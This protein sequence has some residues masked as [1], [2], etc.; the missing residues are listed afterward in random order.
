MQ[1]AEPGPELKRTSDAA[2][3]PTGA[4]NSTTTCAKK[5]YQPQDRMTSLEASDPSEVFD[6][7]E[8]LND[9]VCTDQGRMF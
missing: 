4:R 7:F 6:L 3:P 1:P 5:H 8:K 9:M 2:L